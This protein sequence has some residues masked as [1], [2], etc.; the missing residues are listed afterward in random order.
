MKKHPLSTSSAIRRAAILVPMAALGLGSSEAA[1]IGV[2]F[3]G[4]AYGFG[5]YTPTTSAFG[6]PAASWI[7][8]APGVSG[9]GSASGATVSY[10]ASGS[11]SS[12][13]YAYANVTPP[14]GHMD[15]ND[16][17]M[18]GNIF[19]DT[20]TPIIVTLDLGASGNYSYTLTAIATQDNGSGFINPSIND[21][22]GASTSIWGAT[23]QGGAWNG[24]NTSPLATLT[25]SGTT[26]GDTITFTITGANDTAGIRNALA[27]LTLDFA[28]V[29]EP[30]TAAL[31]AL[32][33]LTLLRRRRL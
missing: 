25:K 9:S 4:S 13:G 30:G 7:N 15:D 18:A 3:Q 22:N 20:G 19:G 31:A 24:A 16:R 14:A 1:L 26:I 2:N 12:Y 6:V 29:P 17:V 5:P 8:L 23:T 11:W 27:G 21:G 33:A 28:P 32:G 10:S